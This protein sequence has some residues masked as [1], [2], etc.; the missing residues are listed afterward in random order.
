[1]LC[2]NFS[3]AIASTVAEINRGSQFFS[4]AALAQTPANF[5]PKRCLFLQS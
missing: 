2:T 5:G 1:M 4:V 3:V